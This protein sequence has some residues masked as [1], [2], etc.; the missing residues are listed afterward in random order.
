MQDIAIFDMDRTITKRGTYTEFLLFAATRRQRWR[1]ILLPLLLIALLGAG[2]GTVSREH[3]KN[4][5]FR[6]MIGRSIAASSLAS[7]TRIFAA[8]TIQ[9]NTHPDAREQI[10]LEQGRNCMVVMA[11][12]APEYY[13]EEIGRLLGLN[14]VI[15]TVQRRDSAGDYLAVIEGANCY[16]EE[17]LARIKRWMSAMGYDRTKTSIRFYSDHISDAPIFEW[18][19]SAVVVRPGR[20]L[21]ALA[22]QNEWQIIDGQ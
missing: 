13:A 7:L 14:A 22:N 20:K 5:A 11:T 15:A 12:A 18:A 6:L 4:I 3:Y 2:L 17:K 1:L 8:R 21:R 16:G 10:A 9:Y 19:D